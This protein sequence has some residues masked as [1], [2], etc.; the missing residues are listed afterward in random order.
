MAQTIAT[1][2]TSD[3]GAQWPVVWNNFLDAYYSR[4]SGT[5]RPAGIQAGGEWYNTSTK[6][7][8]FYDGSQDIP[9]YVI[10]TTNHLLNPPIGGGIS[11]LASASTVDIG[12]VPQASITIT[13][14][15]SINSLGDSMK[16]GQI[17]FLTF[18]NITTLTHSSALILPGAADL[19]TAAG[20]VMVVGCMSTGN[21]RLLAFQPAAG[22]ATLS[23]LMT[24][25]NDYAPL[26]DA[27]L[28]G[29]PRCPTQA[30]GTAGT[31]IANCAWVQEELSNFTNTGVDAQT[32]DASGTWTKPAGAVKVLVECWGGGGGGAGGILSMYGAGGGGGGGGYSYRLYNASALS[33]TESVVVGAGG[34]ATASSNGVNGGNGGTTSFSSGSKIV[35]AYGGGGG[36]ASNTSGTA[37]GGGGGG[38]FGNGTVGGAAGGPMPGSIGANNGIVG[39][40]STMGGGGG[41][42]PHYAGGSSYF[43][44]GGGGGG[45]T[46][47][48]GGAGGRSF[49]GGGAG[50]GGSNVGGGSGGI[51]IVG[52]AGGAGGNTSGGVGSVPGGGGGGCYENGTPGVGGAG[53]CI[54]TT[55]F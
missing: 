46:N 42:Y 38:V 50:G 40:D 28:T 55:W 17:K 13:G 3:L 44:G 23:S 16:A 53:R 15:I 8:Y 31:Q 7:V 34:T 37:F 4:L 41:G 27:I 26:N 39:G 11:S 5:S 10:D 1:L 54:V 29:T 19:T 21:Y 48:T 24:V 52:G 18:D 6:T 45:S 51:S 49:Y 36:E 47:S 20:D 43:G 9:Q 14:I 22:N 25:L 12:S 32:F 30:P 33:S 35:A 2:E